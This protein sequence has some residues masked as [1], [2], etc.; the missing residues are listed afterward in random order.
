MDD[1]DYVDN[2]NEGHSYSQHTSFLNMAHSLYKNKAQGTY[3][4]T[5]PKNVKDPTKGG[6]RLADNVHI[7]KV[8]AL[9]S[10]MSVKLALADIPFGVAKGGL[11][12][13]PRNY[14]KA[15]LSR[16]LRRYTIELGKRGF[17]G[18]GVYVP[19][20]DVGTGEWT[21]D[22]MCD[23][24]QTLFGQHDINSLGVVTG[25]S[26]IVGNIR[27]R[28]ESTGL[29]VFYTVRNVLTQP[30]LKHFREKYGLTEGLKGKTYA[31][32]GF[33]NVGYTYSSIL[34]LIFLIPNK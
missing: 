14:S 8:E 11:R 34:F 6:T 1:S 30:N 5:R 20:P 29:G 15:E 28:S 10:L 4:D 26:S 31:F 18:A 12:I 17:I 7:Q 22:I 13:N 3:L 2:E 23:T 21:M 16:L 33:G 25:K 32:Q 24:Y 27:E 19:G 9:A